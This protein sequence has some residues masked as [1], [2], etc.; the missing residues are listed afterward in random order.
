MPNFLIIGAA[1][2]GTTTLYHYLKQHPQV[3]MNPVKETNFFAFEGKKID[4]TGLKVT[5]SIKSYQKEIITNLDL[6]KK[7]FDGVN[8]EIAIG[9]SCPSYLY[10]PQA[11][12]NIKYYTPQA[13]LIIILRDPVER[14]YSNFLHHMRE[15]IEYYDDFLEAVAAESCRLKNNW[16]WGYHYV[17]VSLYYEQVKRYFDLFDRNQVRVYL[18]QQFK[19]KQELLFSDICQFLEIE[20]VKLIEQDSN[21][22]KY[23]ST[24]IPTNTFL[25]VLIKDSNFVK[26]LY[27]AII[28][29]K[30]IRQKI[31]A[32]VNSF[33]PLIKPD[34][35]QETRTKLLPLFKEDILKLQDLIKQDLSIWLQ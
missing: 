6:Y 5:D 30:S 22:K 29:N 7:Q 10:I 26:K 4:F 1:K 15:R 34:L 35:N 19:N 21:F 33:N 13:K 31:T 17:Q 18:F 14:A 2:S 16:W 8:Q 24:G 3:Y 28:R 12:E 23:N 25:D 32:K 20:D 11:A 9:E 27:Q